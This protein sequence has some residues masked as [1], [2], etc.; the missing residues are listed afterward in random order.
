MLEYDLFEVDGS[1]IID[2]FDHFPVIN[3]HEEN[4]GEQGWRSCK[5]TRNPVMALIRF[6][7]SYV[8]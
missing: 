1:D 2:H 8:C 7:A 3:S 5:S 6:S 4:I